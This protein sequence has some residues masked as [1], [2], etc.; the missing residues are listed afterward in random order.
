MGEN[1]INK[2]A[3]LTNISRILGVALVQFWAQYLGFFF[4]FLKLALLKNTVF[5]ICC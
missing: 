3:I 4:D 5:E 2:G 1:V